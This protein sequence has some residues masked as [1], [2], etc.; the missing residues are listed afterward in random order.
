MNFI[1]CNSLIFLFQK[2][3][4]CEN[5]KRNELKNWCKLNW[6][7]NSLNLKIFQKL[8]LLSI[9]LCS[10]T[11]SLILILIVARVKYIHGYLDEDLNK[12][13]WL[14][15]FYFAKDNTFSCTVSTTKEQRNLHQFPLI[16]FI[17][18]NFIVQRAY[19]IIVKFDF[20][21]LTFYFIFVIFI[22]VEITIFVFP[23]NVYF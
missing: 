8:D 17:Y 14:Y 21:I 15:S 23:P 1:F 12:S 16:Y 20:L 5:R 3:M 2:L 11:Y 4:L 9:L 18:Q 7:S 6:L 10:L 19:A 22:F 13:T